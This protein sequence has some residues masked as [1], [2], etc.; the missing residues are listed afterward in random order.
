MRELLGKLRISMNLTSSR[1]S[2]RVVVSRKLLWIAASIGRIAFLS[3]MKSPRCESS[4]SPTGVASDSG[5]FVILHQPT[6]AQLLR[7]HPRQRAGVA[8]FHVE[9]DGID[10]KAIGPGWCAHFHESAGEIVRG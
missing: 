1:F 9:I 5:S 6:I 2:T 8:Q 4:S 10:I 3:S 7:R